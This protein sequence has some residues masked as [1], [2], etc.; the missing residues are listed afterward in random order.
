MFYC[1]PRSVAATACNGRS[2]RSHS[3]FSLTISGN[4]NSSGTVGGGA[5]SETVSGVLNLV[6]LAG[7][8]RLK[9]SK[10]PTLSVPRAVTALSKE[11]G[12]LIR[13]VC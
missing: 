12:T 11:R 2:S 8:E 7:S 6:D 3:V 1:C 10:V 9:H 4:C 5:G 13:D